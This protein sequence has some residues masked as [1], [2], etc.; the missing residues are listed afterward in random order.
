MTSEPGIVYRF[1]PTDHAF[2]RVRGRLSP[3]ARL[4]A[5]LD[6]REWVVA[7]MRVRLRCRYPDLSP[8]EINLKI[9]EEIDRADRRQ[10]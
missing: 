1:D 3:G 7:A 6:A 10:D 2:M 4:Q 8:Q 5:M 9:I